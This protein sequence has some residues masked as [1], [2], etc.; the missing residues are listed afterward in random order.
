MFCCFA[1]NGVFPSHQGTL[2]VVPDRSGPLVSRWTTESGGRRRAAADTP[3][4]DGARRPAGTP[5]RLRNEL[6]AMV[7]D[8]V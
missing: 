3:D 1:R 8:A 6:P 2:M 7:L 4:T 5:A